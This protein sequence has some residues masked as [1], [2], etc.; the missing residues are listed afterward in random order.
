[1]MVIS[2]EQ[3]ER[4]LDLT[5]LRNEMEN[6][7]AELSAGRVT[8]PVRSVV[9][10]AEQDGWFG[11]MPAVYR[12]VI[13]AKLVTFFP[14]NAARS[15]HTHQAAIHLFKA[16]TGEPLATLHGRTITALRT[17]AVSAIATKVLSGPDARVLAI[18]GSG[19]QAR[20]HFQALS[21]VRNFEAV[22][23]WSRTPEHA[24]R[25]VEEIGTPRNGAQRTPHAPCTRVLSAED[26]VRGADVVV[27]VTSAS[28]PVLRGA[29]LKDG[30]HV[31]AVGAVG[32]KAREIDDDAMRQALIVVESRESAMQ[33]SA[34]IIQSG[35]TIYAEIGELLTGIKPKPRDQ[36]SIYKSLGVAVEDVAAARLIYRKAIA[37]AKPDEL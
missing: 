21:L 20:S 22:R 3:S 33:E 17:A 2:E 30:A 36:T 27:A 28:E 1:M 37:E 16:E 11:L 13:G 15:L 31:N 23:V 8:Q 24:Q 26:A 35:A 5:E 9:R 19:V 18:L 10:L 29:W 4:L 6:A 34:D 12:D 7:L 14:R 25:F 32:P